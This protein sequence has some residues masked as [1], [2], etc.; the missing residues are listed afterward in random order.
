MKD[1]ID[2][3]INLVCSLD[4]RAKVKER[5]DKIK[6]PD[7]DQVWEWVAYVANFPN[8]ENFYDT[9]YIEVI[10]N[11]LKNY[12][13]IVYLSDGTKVMEVRRFENMRYTMLSEIHEYHYGKWIYDLKRVYEVKNIKKEKEKERDLYMKFKPLDE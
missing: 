3:L 12:T 9:F 13:Y 7:M 1:I 5:I 4:K 6:Q 2:A 11:G 8:S 10:K